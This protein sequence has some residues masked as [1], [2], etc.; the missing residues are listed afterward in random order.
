MSNEYPIKKL[1]EDLLIDKT[2]KEII[3]LIIEDKEPEE[4]I[5]IILNKYSKS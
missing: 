5:E 3:H 2:E 1:F 4:I